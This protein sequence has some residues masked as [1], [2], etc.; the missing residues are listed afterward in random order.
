MAESLTLLVD[1][2]S[3]EPAATLAL[4]GLAVR[5][6]GRLGRPVTP[7]S[8]LHSSGID[9]KALGGE[10]AEIV[11]PALERRLAAGQNDFILLPL[12]FGPSRA[13]TEYLPENLARLRP[14][15][16]ALRLKIAPPLHAARDNR[17]AHILAQHVRDELDSTDTGRVALVDHGSPVEAVTAVRNELA[18]QVAGL[19]GSRVAAVTP[20]S[21]ERRAGPE[22][23]FGKPLLADLLAEPPWNAGRVVVAMQFLLPG[24]HAGHDGDVAKICRAAEAA[25]PGLKTHMTKLVVEHPLL[26]DIL[27]DRWR[28]AG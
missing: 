13:L 27:A 3:L 15:F 16:P 2:G 21:M 19:L 24:R 18:Q 17:L 20:A 7:V 23:D 5:L 10:A 4:R 22:Y 11:F 25:H 14:R 8:L 28:Q 26:L 6:S 9:P 1:N 12:F